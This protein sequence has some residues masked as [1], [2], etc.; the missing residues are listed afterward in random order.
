MLRSRMAKLGAKVVLATHWGDGGKGAADLAKIVVELCEQPS[1]MTFVYEESDTLWE[2]VSKIAKR[3][4]RASDVTAD[5]KVRAQIRKL[6]R[7]ATATTGLR[8]EDA[9]STDLHCAAHTQLLRHQREVRRAAGAEFIVMVCGDIMTMPGLPGCRRPVRSTGRRRGGRPVLGFRGNVAARKGRP[10]RPVGS[11]G[12]N[13]RIRVSA[14][15]R[16]PGRRQA[17]N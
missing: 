11:Q 10:R 16:R 14:G 4:Y 13:R 1:K 3:V 12:T 8:G 15:N 6:Q 2:K 9:L 17:L 5:N 7:T